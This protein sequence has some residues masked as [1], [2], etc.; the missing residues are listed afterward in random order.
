MGLSPRGHSLQGGSWAIRGAGTGPTL[1]TGQFV[2][3][4]ESKCTDEQSSEPRPGPTGGFFLPC[5][6]LRNKVISL[7]PSVLVASR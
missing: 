3:S 4:G 6:L 7:S 5:M 2:T 1:V